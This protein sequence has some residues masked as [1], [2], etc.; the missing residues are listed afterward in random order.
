MHRRSSVQSGG[1]RTVA[2]EPSIFYFSDPPS[3]IEGDSFFSLR[4]A[5]NRGIEPRDIHK[6]RTKL[7]TFLLFY[8]FEIARLVDLPDLKV[9]SSMLRGRNQHEFVLEGGALS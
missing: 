9:V 1:V 4:I 3:S 5:V 2:C 6:K 8:S 7:V